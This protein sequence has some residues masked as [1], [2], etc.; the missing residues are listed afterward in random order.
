MGDDA[1]LGVPLVDYGLED[2]HA[3]PADLRAAQ[4]PDQLFAFAGKHRPHDYFDPAHIALDDVHLFP[5][6]RV[7]G[8][9]SRFKNEGQSRSRGI[10]IS[11]QL[12]QQVASLPKVAFR[13]RRSIGGLFRPHING[14]RAAA[15]VSRKARRGLD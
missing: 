10:P 9:H 7:L 3:L 2:L 5:L 8:Y 11:K 14:S 15:H 12:W 1:V 6:L 13:E 4:A